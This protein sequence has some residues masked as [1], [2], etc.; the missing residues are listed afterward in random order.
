MPT[1]GFSITRTAVDC[2]AR[3][4]VLSLPNGIVNTPCFMPVATQGTV[5][6]LAPNELVESGTEI[7]VCN[8]Y[9]LHLRPGAERIRAL[10]GIQ[11]FS[12]WRRPVLTDSGGFQVYSLASLSRVSDEGVLFQS[13]IDGSRHF[14]SPEGVIRIQETLGSD[15]VMCLD[16]CPSFPTSRTVAE[17]SVARTTLWAQ[18]SAAVVA[19]ETNLFGIVQGATY[20][21]LRRRSAAELVDLDL[22]G[23][24][25]GGLCLGEPPTVTYEIIS[26]TVRLIPTDRPRYLMG[27]GYPEDIL[28]AVAEGIDMFDCV[29]P[30]R[31]GRTG[32]AF[33]SGGRVVIRNARYAAD[34][35]P[36]DGNCNCYVCRTFSRAY[37]RHLFVA[38]EAL[39][40]RLLT[41]HNI[42]FF[43]SLMKG[44]RSAL[45]DGR[46]REWSDRFLAQYRSA[47][48]AGTDTLGPNE[49]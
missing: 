24:A 47:D 46:V 7:I 35:T 40:P 17:E 32:T 13:H 28:T 12:G 29:L 3:L 8:T 25:I 42:C 37:L 2:S 18:A 15:I 9:H 45:L 30:T 1:L 16:Q 10:G 27:A 44:V 19:A 26:E 38:G 43:Q 4:G 34:P 11:Q 5:K 36:L 20:R 49:E 31:N 41:L 23:Y 39:G 6:T 22:P 14:F 48:T 33:T 21:D